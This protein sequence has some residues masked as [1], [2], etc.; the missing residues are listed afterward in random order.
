MTGWMMEL[1]VHVDIASLPTSLNIQ[2]FD[3]AFAGR[4]LPK[5]LSSGASRLAGIG[6]NIFQEG[7][8][9]NA[10]YVRVVSA[11]YDAHLQHLAGVA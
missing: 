11:N 3:D 5:T 7:S 8:A 4:G 6:L 10:S 9:I 1:Q 2:R